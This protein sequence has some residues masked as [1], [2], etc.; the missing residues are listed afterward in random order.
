[1]IDVKAVD[2]TVL[3]VAIDTTPEYL[4]CDE[5]AEWTYEPTA[6]PIVIPAGAFVVVPAGSIDGENTDFSLPYGTF[7]VIINGLQ[8]PFSETDEG[9]ELEV[10]PSP[11]DILWCEVYT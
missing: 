3:Y 7:E 6:S 8:Q 4:V 2:L 10:A 5:T 9:F 11:G 1:M